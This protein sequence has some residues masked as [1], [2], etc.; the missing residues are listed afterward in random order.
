MISEKAASMLATLL[1]IALKFVQKSWLSILHFCIRRGIV[2]PKFRFWMVVVGIGFI[3]WFLF[4]LPHPLFQSSY[5]TVLEDRNGIFLSARIAPDYQWRFPESDSLSVKF[6]TALRYFED[7]YFYYHPGVNPVSMFRALRQNMRS[8]RVVSGGS[9]ISMQV[10]RLS[11]Q[12]QHRNLLTKLYEMVL[13]FRLELGYS[14]EEILNF[15]ASHAPFG[16]NVV[17]LEAAAW[18]YYGRP[19]SRLSWGESAALAV[20]PN[21]PSLIFPGKNQERYLAKRNRLLDKLASRHIIDATTCELAKAEPLPGKP[22]ALPRIAPHLLN[23]L[24][25]EGISGTTIRSTIDASLQQKVSHIARRYLRYYAGNYIQNM[26]IVVMDTPTGEVL[27]YVGNVELEHLNNAPYVDN[28]LANRSSG[29]ILKPFLYAAMLNEGELLPKSLVSDIPTHFGAYTPENFEK[30]YQGVVPA[31]AA[32]AHSLNIPAVRELDQYG[33]L[34]FH[35]ILQELGFTSITKNP[36]HYGL[37]LILGGAEVNLL[38]T[39]AIYAGMGRAIKASNTKGDFNTSDFSSHRF[40]LKSSSKNKK[41]SKS[42]PLGVASLWFTLE[43]L[44]TVNRPWAE[45]GWEYFASTHKIAW[46]TGTSIGSRDAWSVGVTPAY[47]VGVWV[48]NASGEG[49]PGLT[50][51]THAAPVMFEVFKTLPNANWYAPPRQ[52]MKKIEVCT[53]SG[54]RAGLHCESTQQWVPSSGVKVKACPYHTK[55]FLDS[56]AQY[57]VSADCYP[58]HRMTE[59]TWFVLPPAQEYFYKQYHPEYSP[60]PP[61]LGGCEASGEQVM[62][63]ISPDNNTA[64]FIPRGIDGETGLLVFEAVHRHRDATIYWHLDNEYLQETRGIHKIE[65]APSA[66]KHSLII[67][68]QEGNRIK[69]QFRVIASQ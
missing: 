34:R 59:K 48:G 21:A 67:M 23:K 9:T 68:D 5:S 55:L 44:T 52:Q 53:T 35:H 6:K 60:L 40:L 46:K 20:L 17:G 1:K 12:H 3:G 61:Y 26:A 22:T 19:A 7:E 32:L 64:L 15:Y 47:T 63:L 2:Y 27:G 14:K 13:A 29:S 38:E 50:G 33:V 4:S 42:P 16:G 10:I 43:A 65:V 18:R 31:D 58:V 28:A 11:K 24:M 57:R 36:E 66:G 25:K 62:E 8:G 51:V 41:T 69:R 56:T 54:F 45:I 49:R 37:S 30:T 39:T